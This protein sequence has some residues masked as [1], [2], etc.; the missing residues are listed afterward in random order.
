M[1][2]Y[3]ILEQQPPDFDSFVNGKA[4]HNTDLDL[5]EMAEQLGV[6]SLM[7]FFSMGPE[8][9][10]AEFL[11]EGDLDEVAV[12]PLQWFAAGDGLFTVRALTRHLGEAPGNPAQIDPIL[13]DLREFETVLAEAD[14]R[15]IRWRLAIDT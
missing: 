1:A 13:S 2:L 14:R 11:E 4:L 5:D 7:S 6:P 8:E 10:E 9:I 3:I 12:P 15:Q